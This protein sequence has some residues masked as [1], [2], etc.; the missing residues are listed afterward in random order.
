MIMKEKRYERILIIVTCVFY[1]ALAGLMI[2]Y[3]KSPSTKEFGDIAGVSSSIVLF[4]P[5]YSII[6]GILGQLFTKKVYFAPVVNAIVV[7]V[8]SLVF[9]Y[10]VVNVNMIISL[11]LLLEG[12]IIAYI[13]SGVTAIIQRLSRGKK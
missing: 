9:F 12:F 6:V 13:G 11:V 2:Y 4:I 3:A 5:I 8:F 1:I 10:T 7:L